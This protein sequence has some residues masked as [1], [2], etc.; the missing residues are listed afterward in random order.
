M[1][2]GAPRG[3]KEGLPYPLGDPGSAASA[4]GALRVL[5]GRLSAI[6]GGLPTAAP[7]SWTGFASTVFTQSAR[8]AQQ[9]VSGGVGPLTS[10]AGA[11]TTAG[12]AL[13]DAQDEVDRL[14]SRLKQAREEL[15]RLD[16]RATEAERQAAAA[17]RAQHLQ[18]L[19]ASARRKA[20]HAKDDLE[21]LRR[22]SLTRAT[23]ACA[24]VERADGVA[25]AAV[26][27]ATGAAPKPDIPS[28]VSRYAPVLYYHPDQKFFPADA[29]ADYEKY[30]TTRDEVGYG[31]YPTGAKESYLDLPRDAA[32][33]RGIGPGAPVYAHFDTSTS[34][35]HYLVYYRHND[36]RGTGLKVGTHPGDW[37]GISVRLNGKGEA[38][39]VLYRAHETDRWFSATPEEA[40]KNG[41]VQVFPGLGSQ[42]SYPEPG[43]YDE[44]PGP[45]D[46]LAARDWKHPDHTVD[47]R[48]NLEQ[49]SAQP[50]AHD[51]E[52][53][54]G[55]GDN[56]PN[57]PMGRLPDP[58]GDYWKRTPPVPTPHES[59]IER[60]T[61]DIPNP[62]EKLV[63]GLEAVGG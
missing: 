4:A 3:E 5:A 18:E 24:D 61:P 29:T 42:A 28:V 35:I 33:R 12:Q 10:A 62:L 30:R 55:W 49:A 45:V 53:R 6:A 51:N 46:E 16:A 54:F 63:H 22:S 25:A 2:G 59:I 47:A 17:S 56:S 36:F 7:A 14:A 19:A 37:E 34:T 44:V 38:D 13:Q 21:T 11:L 57:G 41:R 15:A 26:A 1:F 40:I 58:D 8:Q 60:N 32:F 23:A 20:D 27:G 31:G 43:A 39:R 9:G 48:D 50:W 52:T